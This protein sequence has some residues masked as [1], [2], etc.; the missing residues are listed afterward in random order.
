MKQK[1]QI[2]LILGIIAAAMRVAWIF[3]ERHQESAVPAKQE[4]PALDP[5]YYI[6]PKKLYPYDLKTAKAEITKQPVWVKVGYAYA[7]FPYDY[8]TRRADLAHEAGKLLPIQKLDIEDVVTAASPK[9]PGERQVLAVFD[10]DGQSYATPIGTGRG[11]DFR[12]WANEMLFIEDP[13]QLYKHWPA[14]VW[15]AVDQHQVK[16]GMNEL[17]ADFALGIGLLE[18]GGD[19]TDRTLDYPNGGK[20]VKI[21]YHNGKVVDI[22]PGPAG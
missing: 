5:D 22:T 15:Q 8:T 21:S 16:P 2:I 19:S 14:D 17:Q 4:A 6:H 11:G 9:N 20:P 10:Q 1:I 7:Y 13:H 3:Y 12:F 18:S